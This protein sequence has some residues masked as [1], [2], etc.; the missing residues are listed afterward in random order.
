MSS[1]ADIVRDALRYWFTETRYGQRHAPAALAAL[2]ALVCYSEV[3]FQHEHE[4]RVAAEAD[5]A[6]LREG[7]ERQK[8]GADDLLANYRTLEAERDR[9]REALGRIAHGVHDDATYDIL[10]CAL[11]ARAA[12]APADRDTAS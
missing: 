2:N 1:D 11:I 3:E 10:G 5:L 8:R 9:L 12:L 6:L 7:M 4:M